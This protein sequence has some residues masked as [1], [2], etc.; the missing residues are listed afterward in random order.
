MSEE[1]KIVV[2]RE[3]EELFNH[4]GNL[5]IADEIIAAD[6]VS[7]EEAIGVLLGA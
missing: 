5:D 3:M 4:T 1:N 6:Y 2:R 7:Y